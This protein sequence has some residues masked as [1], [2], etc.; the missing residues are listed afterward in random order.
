MGS[1]FN[2]I[3]RYL[4]LIKPW[5]SC[6]SGLMLAAQVNAVLLVVLADGMEGLL[7]DG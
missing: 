4:N 6:G 3:Q 1:V 5:R 2:R 7:P